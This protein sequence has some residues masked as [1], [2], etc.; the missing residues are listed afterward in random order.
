MT[1]LDV[2]SADYH[3]D[4]I[5]EQPS[6]SA[7]IACLLVSK[8]PAH[9]RHAHP[10]LNPEFVPED[11]DIFDVGTVAHSLLLEDDSRLEIIIA[12]NWRTKV[13]QEQRT[14]ARAAGKIPLLQ[15][16]AAEVV[17]MVAA[18]K[19]YI[20][21]HEAKPPLLADGKA[22]QTLVWEE[23]GITLRARLDWLRDDY[24]VVD[25]YKTSTSADPEWF[26]RKAIYDHGYDVKAAFY[27]RAV[28]AVTGV[29]AEFRWLVQEKKAPY[30]LSVVS[31]GP[32]VLAL[33]NEKVQYAIDLWRGCLLNDDWPSYSKYVATAELPAWEEARWM[34]KHGVQEAA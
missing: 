19:V 7:S 2:H 15:K 3:A 22:E 28:K 30:A 24:A 25:D 21:E 5:G 6:L 20:A 27:L 29:D 1:I 16:H 12:D 31:P 11:S 33:A 17:A 14:E 10:R 34:E 26:A 32:D 8:S 4:A 9:A 23:S 18:A 13:A